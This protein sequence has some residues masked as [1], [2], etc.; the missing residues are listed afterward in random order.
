[1]NVEACV[2]LSEMVFDNWLPEWTEAVNLADRII[3]SYIAEFISSLPNLII[4]LGDSLPLSWIALKCRDFTLRQKEI[5]LL[6]LWP[7]SEGLHNTTALMNLGQQAFNVDHEGVNPI[8]GVI[9]ESACV[10]TADIQTDEDQ[11]QARLICWLSDP[12]AEHMV[13]RERSFDFEK[14][15]AF[16]LPAKQKPPSESA[17]SASAPCYAVT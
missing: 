12:A 11:R 1:M 15:K 14:P 4:G 8:T 7:H 9:P 16:S 5:D 10:R 3:K 13:V 6:R 2:S 17:S